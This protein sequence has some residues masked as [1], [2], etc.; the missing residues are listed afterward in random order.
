MTSL[1][2]QKQLIALLFTWF[3]KDRNDGAVIH[4]MPVHLCCLADVMHVHAD[5]C[6]QLAAR[7]AICQ[8]Q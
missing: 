4:A 6:V 3:A 8:L 5:S 7:L 2:Q 1:A